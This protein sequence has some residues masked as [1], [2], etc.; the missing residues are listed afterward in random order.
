[1]QQLLPEQ[2]TL[3]GWSMGG[4]IATLLASQW[5]QQVERLVLV[6]SNP[7]FLAAGDWPGMDADTANTFHA[8]MHEKGVAGLKRF[9]ML[10]AHGDL[11]ERHV[12]ESL[13][14]HSQQAPDD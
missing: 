5:P 2:C 12:M 14:A 6:A 13:Q 10:V 7:H 4:Q 1:L 9:A 8:L 3:M 11:R